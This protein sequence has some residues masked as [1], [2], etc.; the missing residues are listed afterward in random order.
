MSVLSD[1]GQMTARQSRLAIGS[2][3][4]SSIL[5]YHAILCVGIVLFEEKKLVEHPKPSQPWWSRLPDPVAWLL[6]RAN[7]PAVPSL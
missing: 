2:P 5:Q 7:I 1:E 6:R 4:P 3:T